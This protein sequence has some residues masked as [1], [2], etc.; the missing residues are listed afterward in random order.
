MACKSCLPPDFLPHDQVSAS[1]RGSRKYNFTLTDYTD[2]HLGK[3]RSLPSAMKATYI[4][5]AERP[6]D[7]CGYNY[8]A[9]YVQFKDVKSINTL[10]KAFP[11]AYFADTKQS[12][13]ENRA[14]VVEGLTFD[15]VEI[16]QIG[17]LPSTD[18]KRKC[19]WEEARIAAKQ[20]RFDDIPARMYVPH[21]E[22][23]HAIHKDGK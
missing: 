20:G 11:N 4:V 1:Q 9:G 22:A 7:T 14:R 13:V 17:P 2:E 21:R 5:Y 16:G 12:S 19:E 8:V 18:K 3:V 10:T 15:V 6:C 23:W